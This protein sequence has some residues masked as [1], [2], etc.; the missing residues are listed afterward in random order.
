MESGAFKKILEKLVELTR[1]QKAEVLTHLNA[2][3]RTASVKELEI[4]F[5]ELSCPH[6]SSKSIGHWG[7]RNGL[8]RYRCKNCKKTFN[9]LTGTPLARLRK[10]HLW[11]D[12]AQGMLD[13]ESLTDSSIRLD[14]N[15]RTAFK[16]RHRFLEN[17][18]QNQP[19]K[20]SGIVEND[21]TFFLESQ[22]GCQLGLNRKARKRAGKAS[23]RGLSDQQVCV[24][25]SRDR[26]G[27]TYDQ[28]FEK[29]NAE[30]LKEKFYPHLAKDALF[31]SDCK[32]VYKKFAKQNNIKH[33]T[34]NASKGERVRDGIIHIQNINSYHSRLKNW[35]ENFRGVAT[36]YLASY[37]AWFRTMEETNTKFSPELI[38]ATAKGGRRY[39]STLNYT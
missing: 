8:R 33:E 1:S 3:D 15:K 11:K 37:L 39:N 27:N 9:S 6:C 30:V 5:S 35:V 25:V 26:N 14:I 10:K 21:E 2:Q 17:A 34:L 24:F 4:D 18:Q 12:Y 38:L 23:K 31:C 16:W 22:K 19:E 29:F 32:S 20:L 28:I 13:S 36:K 7:F